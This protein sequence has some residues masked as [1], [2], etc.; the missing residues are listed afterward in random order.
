MPEGESLAER[1]REVEAGEI[2]VAVEVGRGDGGVGNEKGFETVE[3]EAVVGAVV[4]DVGEEEGTD[5]GGECREV[6][7]VV[8]DLER[9][10]RCRFLET[11]VC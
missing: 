3:G 7:L 6:V 10:S 5:L 4:R 2:F 8:F 11:N 1:A 9:P